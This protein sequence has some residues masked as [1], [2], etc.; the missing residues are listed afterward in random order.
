MSATT[1]AIPK[2]STQGMISPA[3][4]FVAP[5]NTLMPG[6]FRFLFSMLQAIATLQ[7]EVTTLQNRL[8]A[9]GL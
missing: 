4:A 6:S 3:T 5:D 1:Q 9:A 7:D 2:L 8:T